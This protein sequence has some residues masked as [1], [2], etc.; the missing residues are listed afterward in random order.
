MLRF[1]SPLICLQQVVIDT[2]MVFAH[3]DIKHSQNELQQ[4]LHKRG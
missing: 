1:V 2:S 4:L 3:S